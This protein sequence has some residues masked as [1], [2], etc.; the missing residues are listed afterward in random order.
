MMAVF[1]ISRR[2]L[3]KA[4]VFMGGGLM[5]GF[6]I[7]VHETA[8]EA[9][10]RPLTGFPLNAFIR[11]GANDV[12]TIMVNK[13]EMG[14]GVYTSLPMLVAEELDCDWR[15]VRVEGAPVHHVY[16]HTQWGI[17]ATGGSTSIATEW[18][19][20]RKAGATARAMLIATA[21]AR[22]KVDP[23]TCRTDQGKVI[24][25]SGKE[26][27]YGQLADEAA[28]VPVPASVPLKNPE[29]YRLIGKPVAR[30]DTPAKT[31][32]TAIFGIDVSPPGTLT[33]VIARPPVFGAKL[34]AV[35]DEKAKAVVG[36]RHVVTVP[37]GVAVV[38]DGFWPAKLGRD[39]LEFEWDEGP[40][41]ALDTESQR[42][43]Y[44][45]RA[46]TPGVVAE[47]RGDVSSAMAA[48]SKT[49]EAEY[50]VPYLAHAPMEP[51]NCLVDPRNGFCDIWT[52]TQF[53]TVDRNAAAQLLGLQPEQ[54]NLRTTLLGG[55]FGRRA[56]PQSDFVVE[57]VQVAMALKKR[58][59]VVWTREDDIKGGYYRPLWLSQ[60]SAG[61]DAGGSLVAWKHTIVGQSIMAGTPFEQGMNKNQVD[62]TSV[63]GA[64]ELPYAVPNLL[65]DLHSTVVGVPVQWWRS[66]GHSH[67]AFVVECFL[68]EVAHAAGKDPLDFRRTLLAGHER[69]LGVLEL[70]AGKV[71][72]GKPLPKG[73]GRGVAV[74][75][76]FDSFVA[77]VVEVSVS[78]EGRATVHRVVCAVDCGRVVNPD[79]VTAQMESG[80]V[81]GLSAALHGEITFKQ[82]KVEQ[83]NFD[84]YEVLRMREMPIVEVHVVQSSEPPT[85]TGEPGVP[86][87]APAVVNAVFAA[88]GKRVR[89]LPIRPHELKRV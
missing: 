50:E 52:G 84:D 13:S 56:N 4:G 21:A 48:A 82:G 10:Q 6:S 35:K 39:A 83:G 40:L 51:L 62:A 11:V 9:S 54:V 3:L 36:V 25:E 85:G 23:D 81:F 86:P 49:L 79:S 71:D 47:K 60:I 55:G 77:Q 29:Q 61:L 89:K 53:Q 76:S 32:G 31:D 59:K 30:L 8:S 64:R 27:S 70:A 22:W 88:T 80:I 14:Q 17:Q 1:K 5:L 44:S 15:K 65:V 20:F 34:K 7:P 24:H 33:A 2:D 78:P 37:A 42:K 46:R 74:H 63:E 75:K 72:W 28:K 68:D 41:A 57:A 43:E 66:V 73:W 67:T 16:N 12:V 19:R 58:V 26:L 87:V 18:E 45:E 38:A 69:H